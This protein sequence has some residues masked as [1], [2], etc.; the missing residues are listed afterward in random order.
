MRI[1]ASEMESIAMVK[2]R[3]CCCK[4]GIVGQATRAVLGWLALAMMAA[5][6][7][8]A[9]PQSEDLASLIDHAAEAVRA[10]ASRLPNYTCTMT[11]DRFERPPKAKEFARLDRVRLEVAM[12]SNHELYAWPGSKSFQ[13]RPLQDMLPEGTISTGE[14]GI[15][16]RAIFLGGGTAFRYAGIEER[17]GRKV[18]H[19]LF[20]VPRA[21]SRYRTMFPQVS[22]VVGYEGSVWNDVET[23]DLVRIDMVLTE[24]PASLPLRNGHIVIDYA[25][26]PVGASDFLLPQSVDSLFNVEGR[27]N[28]NQTSFSG[29]REY[30]TESSISFDAPTPTAIT[31]ADAA[32]P[33]VMPEGLEIESRLET[34]LDSTRL[35]TG[36][37]F[38]AVV[39]NPVRRKGVVLAPKGARIRGHVSRVLSTDKPY[40]CVAVFFQPEWIEFA[41]REGAFHA[42]QEVIA[43]PTAF[44]ISRIHGVVNSIPDPSCPLAPEPESAILLIRSS[45]FH[46]P[47]GYQIVWRTLNPRPQGRELGH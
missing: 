24:I 37:P 2:Q 8:T 19:F 39:I 17:N 28:R 10:N 32:T 41:G 21:L 31:S 36:D 20:R 5:A 42:E 6:Q 35:A 11:V 1:G 16:P 25:R 22:D 23:L 18:H 26:M 47:A 14:F 33:I 4:I 46:V 7:T 27:E 12:V 43:P 15:L 40:Y 13:D 9:K 30:R 34:E 38:E 45:H 3:P 29:C 44:P